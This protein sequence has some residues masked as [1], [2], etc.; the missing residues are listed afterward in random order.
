MCGNL[1]F[2][3]L[4]VHAVLNGIQHHF[5]V[6]LFSCFLGTERVRNVLLEMY[7]NLP[8]Q[9]LGQSILCCFSNWTSI[10]IC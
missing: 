7:I 9:A 10:S 5:I 3:R 8:S 4:L 6:N 2:F 1:D